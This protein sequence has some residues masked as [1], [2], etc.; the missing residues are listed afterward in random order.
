MIWN[1]RKPFG[2]NMIEN[3]K[4][5]DVFGTEHP[6]E[7]DGEM[8]FEVS[9]IY[10]GKLITKRVVDRQKHGL[11]PSITPKKDSVILVFGALEDLTS[12]YNACICNADGSL[13][14][15]LI[16]PQLVSDKYKEYEKEVGRKEAE[17]DIRF[18]W[19]FYLEKDD[20]EI[21]VMG[22]RFNYDWYEIRELDPNTGKFGKCYG[23]TKQ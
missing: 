3:A 2:H 18:L 12:P 14:I 8:G 21:L 22:V 10:G 5:V 4:V 15:N 9:W 1:N 20:K 11:I 6:F 23:A 7:K 16:P 17:K 19:P 13:R